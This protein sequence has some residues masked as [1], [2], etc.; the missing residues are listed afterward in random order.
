MRAREQRL[1]QREGRAK[2]DRKLDEKEG[3]LGAFLIAFAAHGR[4]PGTSFEIVSAPRNPTAE[5]D[6]FARETFRPEPDGR[7]AIVAVREAYHAWCRLRGCEPL[8]DEQIGRA[9]AAFFDSVGVYRVGTG[10]DA[11][12]IVLEWAAPLEFTRYERDE[13]VILPI[14]LA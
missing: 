5:A 12:I 13:D 4:R 14:A 6:A 10:R 3:G 8:P 7:V 9:L 1:K 2:A 11:E